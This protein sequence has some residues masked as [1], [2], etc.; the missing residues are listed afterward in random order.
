MN[1]AIVGIVIILCF[2]IYFSIKPILSF[3]NNTLVKVDLDV[4]LVNLKGIALALG[5]DEIDKI[6]IP[7]FAILMNALDY[8]ESIEEDGIIDFDDLI[9]FVMK[10]L[11]IFEIHITEDEEYLID[12]ACEVIA[13][14]VFNKRQEL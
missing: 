8:A 10:Q 7:V 14:Y 4:V 3:I 11:E 9:E 5:D 1:F 13:S 6:T 2:A 12:M